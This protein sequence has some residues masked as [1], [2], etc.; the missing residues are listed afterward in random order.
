MRTNFV[1]K[2]V[3]LSLFFF[4]FSS[5]SQT[6][7]GAVKSID[8]EV[9]VSA[10]VVLY[11]ADGETMV[12][13][14]IADANGKWSITNKAKE[15]MLLSVTY[16]GYERTIITILPKHFN[17][18]VELILKPLENEIEAVTIDRF[19]IVAKGDTITYNM[20]KYKQASDQTLGG[21]IGKLPGIEIDI[22]GNI[23]YN[24]K[25]IDKVLLEGKDIL[26]SQ[27]KITSEGIQ[28]KDVE[29]ISI[30]E[31]Y[32]PFDQQYSPFVTKKVAMDISL[33]DEAKHK[34]K[35]DIQALG[36]YKKAYQ[37][38]LNTYKV[39]DKGGVTAFVRSNNIG[40]PVMS[41]GDFLSLQG[42]FMKILNQTRGDFSKIIPKGFTTSNDTQKKQNNVLLVNYEHNKNEQHKLRVATMANFSNSETEALLNRA[43]YQHNLT[44]SGKQVQ[45]IQFPYVFSKVDFNKKS[46]DETKFLFIELPMSA[47]LS[48]DRQ[49]YTGNLSES[50]AFVRNKQTQLK[51]SPEIR[52]TKKLTSQKSIL[53]KTVGNLERNY[54]TNYYNTEIET[55]QVK[56][57]QKTTSL[58]AEGVYIVKKA[59]FHFEH[60]IGVTNNSE[61]ITAKS[62]NALFKGDV[63]YK[64]FIPN[65]QSKIQYGTQKWLAET[66]IDLAHSKHLFK[67]EQQQ[68]NLI[69]SSVMTR[70]SFHLLH[71]ILLTA[72]YNQKELPFTYSNNLSTYNNQN[73]LVT[74]TLPFGSFYK[75]RSVNLNYFWF[76]RLSRFRITNNISVARAKDNLYHQFGVKNGTFVQ[77]F[78]QADRQN[79]FTLNNTIGWQIYDKKL[80]LNS[81]TLYVNNTIEKGNETLNHQRITQSIGVQYEPT[82]NINF[83]YKYNIVKQEANSLT[84]LQN[85]T[86]NATTLLGKVRFENKLTHSIAQ[87]SNIHN[88][89]WN[90]NSDVDIRLKNNWSILAKGT[91][92]FNVSPQTVFKTTNSFYYLET[93]QYQ[94]FPSTI[95]VGFQKLF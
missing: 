49:F 53:L 5:Y 82:T 92:L 57:Q 78:T 89:N 35:G 11:E 46:K 30:I 1:T 2:V 54:T 43:Y 14:S 41:E 42:N 71:Y 15:R 81:S 47:N 8:D 74:N 65:V 93:S 18:E 58:L 55:N 94:H 69:N 6:I 63:D 73:I 52:F 29:N 16:I 13:F 70:Y 24:G 87:V 25:R 33:T 40:E 90:L 84:T 22:K 77:I 23:T 56:R 85:H 48:N 62:N 64:N 83:G 21:V 19:D 32:K 37:V 72:S 76:N 95:T 20:N 27:H 39:G 4:P 79:T 75:E 34:V 17:E 51:A 31:N 50:N 44:L 80:R 60:S 68:N 10:S 12:G 45:E 67:N 3:F 66:K 26:N 38:A 61:T 59:P 36:G 28:A 7:R 9:L 86:F 88:S 91:D